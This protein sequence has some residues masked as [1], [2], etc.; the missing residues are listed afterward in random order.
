MI[1]KRIR[2][3][4]LLVKTFFMLMLLYGT[5]TSS[6]QDVDARSPKTAAS[7]GKQKDAE[8]KKEK[9]KKLLDKAIEKGRKRHEKLQ[10]KNTKRMMRKSKKKAKMWNE[11]KKGFFLT[12]WMHKKQR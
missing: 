3:V 4:S 6:G 1:L 11:N 7:H 10:T 2:K 5:L 12:R 9:Q 8:K